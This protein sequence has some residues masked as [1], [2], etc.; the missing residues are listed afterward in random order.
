MP[1]KPRVPWQ[2]IAW[3][4]YLV[5][6]DPVLGPFDDLVVLA[7]MEGWLMTKRRTK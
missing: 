7:L 1:K 2:R 6:P 5:L 3:L 4:A